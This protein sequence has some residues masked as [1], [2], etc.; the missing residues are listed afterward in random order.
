MLVDFSHNLAH[1]SKTE[2]RKNR[3]DIENL[4]DERHA[5]F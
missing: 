1:F 2:K 5:L 4:K 3:N